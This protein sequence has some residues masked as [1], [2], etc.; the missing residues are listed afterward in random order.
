MTLH[1]YPGDV[2]ILRQDHFTS[3]VIWR[4]C[5]ASGPWHGKENIRKCSE[6]MCLRN[7]KSILPIQQKY[8]LFFSKND[9]H[10]TEPRIRS[11]PAAANPFFDLTIQI[12]SDNPE[13]E[14]KSGW[15][16]RIY[17]F[18]AFQRFRPPKIKTIFIKSMCNCSGHVIVLRQNRTTSHVRVIVRGS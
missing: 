17:R 13:I 15:T 14:E 12:D 7:N 11:H 18:Q 9:C 4:E 5:V 6:T 10:M 2:I 16:K 3:H 8:D 1:N